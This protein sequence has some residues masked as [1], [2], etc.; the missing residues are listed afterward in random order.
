MGRHPPIVEKDLN[1]RLTHREHFWELIDAAIHGKN[2]YSITANVQGQSADEVAQ[3]AIRQAVTSGLQGPT[4]APVYSPDRLGARQAGWYSVSIVVHRADLLKVMAHLHSIHGA[5]I[6]VTPVR[7]ISFDESES[8][9]NLLVR[10]KRE[11]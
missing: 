3:K 10:L 9:Q 4:I 2:Y 8:Y 6:V 1:D 7:Y 11:R 5:H